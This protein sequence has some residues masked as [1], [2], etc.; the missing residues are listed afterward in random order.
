MIPTRAHRIRALLIAGLLLAGM[1]ALGWRLYDLQVIRHQELSQAA[2]RLRRVKLPALRGVILDCNQNILAHSIG[3]H[4]VVVD[5]QVVDEE[6]ARLA[7][8]K[9]PSRKPEL[10]QVLSDQLVLPRA[11]VWAKLNESGRYSVLKRNV[12]EETAQNLRET[13]KEKQLRG[14]LFEDGQMRFYPNGPLMSHVLGYMNMEQHGVDGVELMMQCDLQGQDGWRKIECDRRGREIVV[15]RNEDFPSRNGYSVVLT[16]DQAIQSIVEQVLDEAVQEYRPDSAVVIVMRPATGEILAL[17]NRPTF[18]PNSGDK[19]IEN[20][21]NPA[22][23]D[24]IEPGSTFKIVTVAAALDQRIVSLDDTVWC[25]NGKFFYGGRYLND[26]APF[27]NLSVVNVLVHSSNIGAAK[28]ALM[29]GNERMHKAMLN[30]GFGEK[31]F[32]DRPG[33]R[34]PGEIRGIVHPLQSW[35]QVSITR[36]AMGHEVAVTPLQIANAMCAIANGGN[37]MRPQ[38]IKRVVQEN[39]TVV[40]EFFPQVRRRV[41]DRK[42]AQEVN[43]ALKQ[44]VGKEGT[45]SRAAVPGFEVAGKTGTAQKVVNGQYA[46]DRFVASFSGYF[47][48]DDPE[49]CIYV[50]FDHP[51]SREYS[52]GKIAAP[53]FHDIAVRVASY[54]NLKPSAEPSIAAGSSRDFA[55]TTDGGIAR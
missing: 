20:L 33:E 13:L 24:L 40:R 10:L 14:V 47:P 32:G 29:L 35:S 39:G 31:A 2:N 23:S 45:A 1:G 26:H 22:I 9:R 28:I 46:N 8:A 6:D 30:F 38:I 55:R 17:A 37:L 48:A 21:K 7:R 11:E 52:G 16:L 5:P 19:R 49:L 53:V 54:M 50:M 18:N 3:V 36:V 27:G 15:F 4:T 12:S 34:W 51:K 25:E 43:E 44:V 41:V 42:A